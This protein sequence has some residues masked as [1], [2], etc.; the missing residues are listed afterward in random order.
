MFADYSF[1]VKNIEIWAPTFF[2]HNNSFVATVT[3]HQTM[4]QKPCLLTG[5]LKKWLEYLCTNL[6]SLGYEGFFK[7]QVNNWIYENKYWLLDLN[8]FFK[9]ATYGMPVKLLPF[10]SSVVNSNSYGFF[11]PIWTTVHC[12]RSKMRPGQG[13]GDLLSGK[14]HEGL[15]MN[16]GFPRSAFSHGQGGKVVLHCIGQ[17]GTVFLVNQL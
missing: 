17:G 1:E 5:L 12:V 6:K 2:K 15:V 13:Q 7:V 14:S 9:L 11:I 10:T 8:I 16:R 3:C 4:W